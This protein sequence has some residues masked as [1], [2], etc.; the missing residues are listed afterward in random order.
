MKLLLLFLLFEIIT[1]GANENWIPITSFNKTKTPKSTTKLDINLSQ[2]EPINK[3]IKN[4]TAIKQ[5]IDVGTK[6]EAST[7]NEKS[8]FILKNETSK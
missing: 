1:Q 5:L 7:T 8:W 3:M 2:I 4:I 6:K